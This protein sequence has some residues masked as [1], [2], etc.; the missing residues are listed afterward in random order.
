V[1][2]RTQCEALGEFRLGR[3]REDVLGTRRKRIAALPAG[4]D[5]SRV[6][7]LYLHALPTLPIRNK[8]ERHDTTAS[9]RTRAQAF[10]S[11]AQALF[12]PDF[13]HAART[14]TRRSAQ[15]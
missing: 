1:I 2:S 10:V 11:E 8:N 6:Q 15:C 3:K 14:R 5:M 13:F 12:N 4:K 7:V 9:R